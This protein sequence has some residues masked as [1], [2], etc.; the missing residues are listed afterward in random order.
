MKNL[1]SCDIFQVVPDARQD[2]DDK[3]KNDGSGEI[4]NQD[5]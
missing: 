5:D 1:T 2:E 3:W 4:D